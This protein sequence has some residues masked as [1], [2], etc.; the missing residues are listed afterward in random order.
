MSRQ[1]AESDHHRAVAFHVPPDREE[2]ARR[3]VSAQLRYWHLPEVV[4]PAADGV[5]LL[6][7]DMRRTGRAYRCRVQ[8]VLLWDRLALSVCDH[9]PDV[10]GTAGTGPAGVAGV[11]WV[12]D[13]GGVRAHQDE[14]GR[15]LWLTVPVPVPDGPPEARTLGLPWSAHA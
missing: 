13:S 1:P 8:L 9:A 5:A 7:A 11:A 2:R 3:I 6:L 14:S 12:R 4:D 10:C 15:T